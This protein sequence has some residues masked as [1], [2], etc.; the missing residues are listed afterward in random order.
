MPKE[1][2]NGFDSR[3]SPFIFIHWLNWSCKCMSCCYYWIPFGKFIGETDRSRP[4]V[5]G[6]L[7][8]IEYNKIL[9]RALLFKNDRLFMNLALELINC[10]LPTAYQIW[11]EFFFEFFRGFIKGLFLYWIDSRNRTFYLKMF[12]TKVF[13]GMLR[14]LSKCQKIFTL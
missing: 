14:I 7:G 10:L 2:S 9:S 8:L 11:E 13:D 3:D 1:I 6:Q 5:M 12:W 4:F